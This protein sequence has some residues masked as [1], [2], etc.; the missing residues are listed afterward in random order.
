VGGRKGGRKEG[1]MEGEG[2]IGGWGE[3]MLINITHHRAGHTPRPSQAA[4][5]LFADE[6]SK[7]ALNAYHIFP[8]IGVTQP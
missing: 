3:R 4:N 7:T 8:A 6:D 1:H 2:G 5:P